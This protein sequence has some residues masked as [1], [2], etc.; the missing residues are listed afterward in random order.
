MK[1]Q[2]RIV[3]NK[4]LELTYTEGSFVYTEFLSPKDFTE[5]L[6]TLDNIKEEIEYIQKKEME[7]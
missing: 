7:R 5:L 4:Y 6:N 3:N 2:T 1:I